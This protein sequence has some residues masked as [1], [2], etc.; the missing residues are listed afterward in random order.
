MLIKNWIFL[1]GGCVALSACVKEREAAPDSVLLPE[2][3]II[4]PSTQA[5]LVGQSASFT[6]TFVSDRGDTSTV[7]PAWTSLSPQAEIT[8][9]GRATGLSVGQAR[10]V[11]TY[12]GLS[13]TAY[14]NV[15]ENVNAL[16]QVRLAGPL[17]EVPIG[18]VMSLT[19]SGTSVSGG[20]VPLS[21]VQYLVSDTSLVTALATAGT[22]RVK[23]GGV[24]SVQATAN[25]ITSAP[26][27]VALARSGQFRGSQGHTGMG[28]GR[29]FVRNG[30]VNVRFL[31]DFSTPS[32]P[33]YRV[34]LSRVAEGS[35]VTQNG[36]QLA[37]LTRFSGEQSY[38]APANVNLYDYPHL[39]IHCQQYNVSVLTTP[40]R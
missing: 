9:Q 24:I 40:L 12:K 4:A 31:S 5:V 32:G 19:A 28:T 1:F 26:F 11:A 35:S 23:R 30:R 36:V 22:Y 17:E 33:D 16:A 3:L 21:E 8:A 10:L 13:D 27:T 7:A 38:V 18:S 39:V 29:V 6:A 37:I 15:A 25:G 14:L 34:Y 2:Q 20:L